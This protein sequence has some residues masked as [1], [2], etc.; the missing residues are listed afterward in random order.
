MPA[1]C[2]LTASAKSA[3][4]PGEIRAAVADYTQ[5]ARMSWS[6]HSWECACPQIVLYAHFTQFSHDNLSS[7]RR[8]RSPNDRV[9][10]APGEMVACAADAN[11]R[12]LTRPLR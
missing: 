8:A 3:G 2:A 6:Y 10:R 1:G 11:A 7:E 5:S 4:E 9:A 12:G